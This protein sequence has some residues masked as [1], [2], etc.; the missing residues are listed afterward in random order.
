MSTTQYRKFDGDPEF[1]IRG[2]DGPAV[3]VVPE[4][5]AGALAALNAR[6][7]EILTEQRIVAA[8][9]P[10]LMNAIALAEQDLGFTY[11]EVQDRLR[12]VV[13]AEGPAMVSVHG[14]L[15]EIDPESIEQD[16]KIAAVLAERG[17]TLATASQEQYLV[18]AAEVSA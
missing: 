3:R 17:L 1:V 9:T 18:A 6:A 14:A 15:M 7:G 10:Q 2:A 16:K 8:T 5:P 4:D 12:G 13:R 11:G